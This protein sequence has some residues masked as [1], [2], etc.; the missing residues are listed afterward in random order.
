MYTLCNK[1]KHIF[2]NIY[3]FFMVKTFKSFIQF[4]EIHST[5][6]LT[7]VTLLCNSA[8]G[9]LILLT[10]VSSPWVNFSSPL[11]PCYSP[12]PLLT[13]Y[14]F[15]RATLLDSIYEWDRVIHVSLCLVMFFINTLSS[16][17]TYVV[18]CRISPFLWLNSILYVS[19]F[20]YLF[21]SCGQLGFSHFWS[22]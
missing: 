1:V 18:K 9:L 4:F 12:Q 20:L 17:S 5:K 10:T 22:L 3:D 21:T 8:R 6:S 16:S 2:S 13:F 14:S 11:S 15:M 19:Y 7:V